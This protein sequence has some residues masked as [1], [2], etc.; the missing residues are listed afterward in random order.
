MNRLEVGI[1]RPSPSAPGKPLATKQHL[2]RQPRIAADRID[3]TSIRWRNDV[4]GSRRGGKR[5][6]AD[7]PPDHDDR[8]AAALRVRQGS[9]VPLRSPSK[10][11]RRPVT[12]LRVATGWQ[13][14]EDRRS[15]RCPTRDH[16]VDHCWQLLL[17]LD[18]ATDG[19]AGG[20]QRGQAV[21]FRGIGFCLDIACPR[22]ADPCEEGIAA[23]SGGDLP[24]PC[25]TSGRDRHASGP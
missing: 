9:R 25:V 3:C 23:N 10:A 2:N 14:L 22:G 18:E 8:P 12:Q 24:H 19:D 20:G 5:R 4:R 6:D 1:G 11:V 7:R 15:G 13:R 17:G 16:R 21:P